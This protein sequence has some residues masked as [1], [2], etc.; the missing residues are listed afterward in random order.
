MTA[1]TAPELVEH[2]VDVGGI[3]TRY[4]E[5]G[6]GAR[7]VVLLHG[8]GPGVSARA[9]WRL[10]MPALA[11]HHRVLA[12]EMV[13]YGASR[14]PA[15]IRY[16]VS[17]W[18][19][20]VT[21][22][23]DVLDVPHASFVGN[24]MG[25][26]ICLHLAITQPRRVERMVLMGTPGVGMRP[27][28]G[29]AAVRNYEPSMDNMRELLTTAFAHDPAIITEDLVRARYEAS[30]AG[31]AHEIYRTMFFDPRHSGNDLELDPAAVGGVSV[32]TLIVHGTDDRVIPVDVAWTMAGLMPDADLH[33]FARCGHWTQIERA[34]EFTRLIAGFLG[35]GR[36]EGAAP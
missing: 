14:G 13:G 6:S 5:A 12:P 32:P 30:V 28:A 7:T 24:S 23:L 10:T 21:G 2:V 26:L 25:G 29:L 35:D 17:T 4:L 18:L 3:R 36:P 31:D 34:E 16:G 19:D 15:D 20:H 9:N 11:R 1:A 22:F 33:V 8:S 27:T